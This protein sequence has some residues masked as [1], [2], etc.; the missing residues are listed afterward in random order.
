MRA[1][2]PLVAQNLI[3]K[4]QKSSKVEWEIS[5]HFKKEWEIQVDFSFGKTRKHVLPYL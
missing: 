3:G 5:S 4:M 2:I 1:A